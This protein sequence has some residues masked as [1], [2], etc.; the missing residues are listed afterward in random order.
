MPSLHLPVFKDFD[1]AKEVQ[2]YFWH[3]TETDDEL[4]HLLSAHANYDKEVKSR[5]S[6]VR[7]RCEW[8]AARVLLH[9][10]A[11]IF[12][13]IV[14]AED[15]SPHL[16]SQPETYISI[17]HTGS[18]VALAVAK[19]PVGLDIEVCGSRALRLKDKFLSEE[20][21]YLL[22]QLI[23]ENEK[24]DTELSAVVLWSAKEAAFKQT[25]CA[26]VLTL[27]DIHLSSH[28]TS[29]T[30]IQAFARFGKSSKTFLSYVYFYTTPDF[31]LTVALPE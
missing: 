30:I 17:S 11:H 14:Y 13:P 28:P 21:Q 22:T 19:K 6:S 20:E 7:R 15:G 4:L 9:R 10:E 18:F 29:S 8:L 1:C 23:T 27:S 2:L 25:Q 16:L 26:D 31:V 3:L 12:A 5:F 24:L